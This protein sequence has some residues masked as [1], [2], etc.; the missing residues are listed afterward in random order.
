[1]SSVPPPSQS[2]VPSSSNNNATYILL[3]IVLLLGVGG[4]VAYKFTSK[5]DNPA[6]APTTSVASA[7]SVSSALPNTIMEDLPPPPPV[8]DAAAPTHTY[9]GPTTAGDPC[10]ATACYGSVKQGSDTERGLQ[11][12]ALQTRR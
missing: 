10:A 8:V 12:L 9:T 11:V 4:I 5:T 2:G 3:A 1:M 7:P 6:P